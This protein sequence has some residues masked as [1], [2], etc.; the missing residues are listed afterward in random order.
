MEL[1]YVKDTKTGRRHALE[2][3]GLSPT[4]T[5]KEKARRLCDE[6]NKFF[7]FGNRFVVARGDDHKDEV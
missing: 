2:G 6:L 5:D 7:G 4:F 3:A 1:F